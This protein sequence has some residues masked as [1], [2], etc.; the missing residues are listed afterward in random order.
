VAGGYRCVHLR[1]STF[2][3]SRGRRRR[4]DAVNYAVGSAQH[5]SKKSTN[6]HKVCII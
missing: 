4:I 1:E 5:K 6:N 3:S 2:G